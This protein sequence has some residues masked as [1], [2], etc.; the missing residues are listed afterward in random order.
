[1]SESRA[2]AA[3]D[4]DFLAAVVDAEQ[5]EFEKQ[6]EEDLRLRM[7]PL[8]MQSGEH[9]LEC[10]YTLWY[11]KRLAPTR[12]RNLSYD[13]LVKAVVSFQSVEQFWQVGLIQSLI[14]YE[15]RMFSI[16]LSRS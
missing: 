3:T 15:L 13:D 10:Y 16:V 11:S 2:A 7:T 14:K 9:P 6:T 4:E 8:P 5:D 1:M 12:M